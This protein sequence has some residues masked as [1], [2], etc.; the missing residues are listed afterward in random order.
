MLIGI[1][2][3]LWVNVKMR[4]HVIPNTGLMIKEVIKDARQTVNVQMW[5]GIIAFLSGY[6]LTIYTHKK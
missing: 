5:I 6:F 1:V 4:N 2:M 3:I